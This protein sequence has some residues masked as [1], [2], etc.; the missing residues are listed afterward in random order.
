MVCAIASIIAAL[1]FLTI[2]PTM[3]WVVLAGLLQLVVIGSLLSARSVI[4]CY[5]AELAQVAESDPATGCLNRRGFARVLDEALTSAVVTRSEVALL[6]LDVDHFKQ[7]NDRYGHNVGDLVLFEV[8]ATLAETVGKEGIVARL[9]G[10]EFS[11]LM[12]GADVE[13]AGVMAERMLANIRERCCAELAPGSVITMSIGIAA[14][15]VS[16]LRDGAAL[17]ARSDEALYMAKRGGRNRVLLWAPGVRSL[18]T[19]AAASAAIVSEP[20]WP[21]VRR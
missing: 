3:K 13:S 11:V 12:P 9:G 19:P 6:S 2:A 18:A 21:A 20:K 1:T 16:S 14:E 15:R 7:V 5:V 10:E 4:S 8:A 17:R